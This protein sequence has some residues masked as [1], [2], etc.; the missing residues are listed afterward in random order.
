MRSV[1]WLWLSVPVE[2][3]ACSFLGTDSSRLYLP[4]D[5][6]VDVSPACIALPLPKAGT[7]VTALPERAVTLFARDKSGRAAE[8]L[9]VVVTL[10]SCR[11]STPVA[12][13]T[14]SGGGGSSGAGQ[15]GSTSTAS[16][17]PTVAAISCGVSA[18]SPAEWDNVVLASQ[19]ND[20]S[21]TQQGTGRLSCLLDP[22]GTAGFVVRGLSTDVSLTE[23][24]VP[25]CVR[26]PRAGGEFQREV[27]AVF[28]PN[29]PIAA[30]RI[31]IDQVRQTT[32]AS[33]ACG[34][35]SCLRGP[36]F[37]LE[38]LHAAPAPG[39][40]GG[41]APPSDGG[42]AN[43]AGSGASAGGAATSAA[44]EPTSGGASPEAP[45]EADI[46]VTPSA[47]PL[48]AHVELTSRTAWISEGEICSQ[49]AT[50]Q[51][52]FDALSTSSH[53]FS[54]CSNGGEES[55][56]GIRAVL[57][58]NLT[59]SGALDG[60]AIPPALQGVS[61]FTNSAG[62]QQLRPA[63]CGGE[64]L[65]AGFTARGDRV[66]QNSSGRYVVD[67]APGSAP[68]AGSTG[69]VAGAGGEPSGDAGS[70]PTPPGDI[71][72]TLVS[73]GQTCTFEE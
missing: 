31:L 37:R 8:S 42:E 33:G 21:C 34:S 41:G 25:M 57:L 62:E 58:D 13:G 16:P 5:G 43:S 22:R 6:V 3:L 46:N 73:T 10:G 26:A 60:V 70:A 71:S 65:T 11:A 52:L 39:G 47:T 15:A 9:E 27:R 68:S 14:V 17:G 50:N 51:V 2:F 72:V 29:A 66:R 53:T 24:Y 28:S 63:L 1:R 49:I 54:V 55:A 18:L 32:V 35:L 7:G 38:L 19:L 56:I 23:R 61:L 64:M 59:I 40:G 45:S 12:V 67:S 48:I 30:D 20:P 36:A 69:G 4:A 44:P